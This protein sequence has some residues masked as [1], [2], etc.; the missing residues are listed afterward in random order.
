M[1]KRQKNS[2]EQCFN[3][4]R[5][6]YAGVAKCIVK[7]SV[8][9]KVFYFVKFNFQLQQRMANAKRKYNNNQ[10]FFDYVFTFAETGDEHLPQCVIFLKTLPLMVS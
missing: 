3:K 6:V 10:P 8:E 1:R 5:I 7:V 2:L 4:I 9:K